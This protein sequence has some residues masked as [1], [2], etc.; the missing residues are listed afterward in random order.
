MSG[1]LHGA[2][3]NAWN[4]TCWR[5]IFTKPQTMKLSPSIRY[6]YLHQSNYAQPYH[7]GTNALVN[8]WVIGLLRLNPQ[9]AKE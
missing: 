4:E 6:A 1:E 8:S 7:G 5:W 3:T 2:L 9:M